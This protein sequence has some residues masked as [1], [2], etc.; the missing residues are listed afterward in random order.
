MRNGVNA[1]TMGQH[2]P[3]VQGSH[4][5][6]DG[7]RLW[8]NGFPE[9]D[10]EFTQTNFE[11]EP[12]E[13]GA[14][15]HCAWAIHDGLEAVSVPK[16]E[17]HSLNLHAREKRRRDSVVSLAGLDAEEYRAAAAFVFSRAGDV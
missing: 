3:E 2:G 17:V 7:E 5:L 1:G 13:P 4:S 11:D 9:A 14:R 6:E 10:F 15:T 16:V 12:I 8:R